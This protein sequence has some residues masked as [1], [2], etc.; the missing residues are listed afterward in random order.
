LYYALRQ[1]P[2][3]AK[4]KEGI[5]GFVRASEECK[6]ENRKEKRRRDQLQSSPADVATQ[7][8]GAISQPIRIETL[9]SRL[10]ENKH[11]ESAA[12]A[13]TVLKLM[14]LYSAV[15]KSLAECSDDIYRNVLLARLI[16]ISD[17]IAKFTGI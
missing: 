6:I 10:A 7:L 1:V 5:S 13:D 17:R 9:E 12:M 14:E 2:E 4:T 3:E 11:S 8:A 15:K 16:N